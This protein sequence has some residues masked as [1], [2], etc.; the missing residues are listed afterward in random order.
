[1]KPCYWAARY[2][3]R[4][5]INLTLKGIVFSENLLQAD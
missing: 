5:L 4:L 3:T 1:M 2:N